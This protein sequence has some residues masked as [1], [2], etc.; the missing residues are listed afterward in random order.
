MSAPIEVMDIAALVEGEDDNSGL[1]PLSSEA[2][3]SIW[4]DDMIEKFFC[5]VEQ[6]K[7]WK[8]KWCNKCFKS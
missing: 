8:Y 1:E 3:K 4:D 6:C 7:K 2:P 5:T